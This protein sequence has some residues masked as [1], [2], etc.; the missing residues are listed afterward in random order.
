MACMLARVTSTSLASV[1]SHRRACMG[2]CSSLFMI[3]RLSSSRT[4]RSF[5]DIPSPILFSALSSSKVRIASA[6]V[7]SFLMVGTV[8]RLSLH[9]SKAV[10]SS[11]S[12]ASASAAACARAFLLASTTSFR[13]STLYTMA[14]SASSMSFAMFRGTEMSKNRRTPPTLPPPGAAPMAATSLLPTRM[15]S[16]PEA[17]NT[18][19]AS[20]T[21]R[22]SSGTRANSKSTSG[23]SAA[24]SSQRGMERLTTVILVHPLDCRCF[25][26]SRV[27]F[28]APMMQ[29]RASLKSCEGSFIWHSSAAAEDT[30]TAP[31]AMDVSVRT[32]FPA[33][34]ACLNRPLRWRSYP[35]ALCPFSC[36]ALTWAKICPSPMT[37]ESSPAETRKRCRVASRSRSRKR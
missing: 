16:D 15:D 25:T 34:M 36:T 11:T 4:L 17:A 23:K 22:I 29:I 37:S 14:P 27:I 33:W 20:S 8:S 2:P 3:P 19:S 28:P 10:C 7:R 6:L 31:L 35:L 18:T 30:E 9:A 24:S 32:R 5:F 13:S 1:P 12:S 26:S 21:L